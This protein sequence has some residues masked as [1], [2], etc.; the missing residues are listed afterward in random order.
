MGEIFP[1]FKP[2]STFTGFIACAVEIFYKHKV[3]PVLIS[4]EE[5]G[6]M[7]S[8]EIVRPDGVGGISRQ[9]KS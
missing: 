9:E 4:E 3:P 8:N 5:E 2:A 1:M 6:K 7:K